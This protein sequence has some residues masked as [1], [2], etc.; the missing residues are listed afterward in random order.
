MFVVCRGHHF[1]GTCSGEFFRAFSASEAFSGVLDYVLDL[2]V[3]VH[4]WYP[5]AT[6]EK[7]YE[8]DGK[9]LN[10]VLVITLVW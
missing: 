10:L 9:E 4:P 5:V 2:F 3:K 1:Q 7:Y 6:P 8:K